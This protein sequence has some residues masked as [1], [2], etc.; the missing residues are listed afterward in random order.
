MYHKIVKNKEYRVISSNNSK[1]SNRTIT[2]TIINKQNSN[3]Q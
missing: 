3:M 2:I 1:H